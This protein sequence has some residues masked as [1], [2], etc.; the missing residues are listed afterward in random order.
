MLR[1]VRDRIWVYVVEEN[2]GL[3]RK[4]GKLFL[5]EGKEGCMALVERFIIK[6]GRGEIREGE[7]EVF[8]VSFY[9]V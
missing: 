1:K 5:E 4:I 7:R 3:I 2:R 9:R 8:N 6:D